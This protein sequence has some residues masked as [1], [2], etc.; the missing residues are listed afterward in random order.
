M[1]EAMARVLDNKTPSIN[2]RI[3]TILKLTEKGWK[4]GLRFDPLIYGEDWK[5]NYE[6]LL[7]SVFSIIP[8][9][10]IHSVTYGSLRFPNAMYKTI[11]KMYP[12]DPLFSGPMVLK[13]GVMSYN[14]LIENEMTDYCTQIA[15]TYVSQTKIFSCFSKPQELR[16]Q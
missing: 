16:P 4:V 14:K 9:D 7:H 2:Q 3:S 5:N 13:G 12:E 8:G 15:K 11:T 10:A 1:P 6:N